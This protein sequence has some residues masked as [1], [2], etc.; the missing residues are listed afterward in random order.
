MPSPYKLPRTPPPRERF[1]RFPLLAAAALALTA[2][3][4]ETPP[5]DAAPAVPVE[6]VVTR[7]NGVHLAKLT[8]ND[9]MRYNA[10]RFNLPAGAQVRLTLVNTG[11]KPR[12]THGHNWVLLPR[13]ADPYDFIYAQGAT[14]DNDYIPPAWQDKVLAH[15]PVLGPGQNATITFTAPTEPGEYTYLCSFPAHFESGMLGT[16]VI[17]PNDEN[18][19]AP[20]N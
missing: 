2:C 17:T 12:Q 18:P 10:A 11:S 16:L 20:G 8:A 3:G 19:A 4:S 5:A 15:T 13:N 7:H 14:L 1:I 9:A 6:P